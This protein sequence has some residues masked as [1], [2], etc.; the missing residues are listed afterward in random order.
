MFPVNL[1]HAKATAAGMATDKVEWG[2][3]CLGIGA[4]EL[5]TVARSIASSV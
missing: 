3:I 1:L 5:L 4:S 2:V